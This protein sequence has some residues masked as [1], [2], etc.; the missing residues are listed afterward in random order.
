MFKL[1]S[2]LMILTI[3]L[4]FYGC[5]HVN[6]PQTGTQATFVGIDTTAPRADPFSARAFPGVERVRLFAVDRDRAES[7][8]LG[9]NAARAPRGDR[10]LTFVVEDSIGT[11]HF[12]FLRLTVRGGERFYLRPQQTADGWVVHLLDSQFGNVLK[13]SST[14]APSWHPRYRHP[15]DFGPV[16]PE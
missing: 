8:V 16:R 11:A 15:A 9:G 4:A 3:G 1:L 14:Q 12:S 6:V 13:T 10:I 2:L 5:G 7:S